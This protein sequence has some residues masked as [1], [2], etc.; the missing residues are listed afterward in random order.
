MNDIF[1]PTLQWIKDDF[2][3]NRIRFVIELLAWAISVGC[4]ITMAFTVPNPPLLALYPVWITGCA[5][6][7]WASWT[8]KSFGMLANYI[9]LTTIDTIGLIRMVI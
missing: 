6:Y 5:L 8:R 4:S 2:K 1:A 3:S 7:A 9:L